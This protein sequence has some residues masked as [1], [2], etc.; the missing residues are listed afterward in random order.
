[1]AEE[2]R[3]EGCHVGGVIDQY[4]V[5]VVALEGGL[6]HVASHGGDPLARQQQRPLFGGEGREDGGTAEIAPAEGDARLFGRAE[7]EVAEVDEVEI[8]GPQRRQRA[9]RVVE[10][11]QFHRFLQ[12]PGQDVEVV[13]GDPLEVIIGPDHGE[14]A[15]VVAQHPDSQRRHFG[16]PGWSAVLAGAGGLC[17]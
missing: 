10:C 2:D 9:A 6:V 15:I 13:G 16:E 12:R 1:M 8:P 11:P 3:I 7:V 14:R 5:R 17:R 4:Q